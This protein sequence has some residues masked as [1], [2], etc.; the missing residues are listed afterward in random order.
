MV[1][2]CEI[3]THNERKR[4]SKSVYINSSDVIIIINDL[5]LINAHCTRVEVE[6]YSKLWHFSS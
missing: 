4:V 2:S 6:N 5:Y 1:Y 3:F